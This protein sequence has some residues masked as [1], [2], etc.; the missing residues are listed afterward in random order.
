MGFVKLVIDAFI[1]SLC[2][3]RS[4]F[5]GKTLLSIAENKQA[6]NHLFDTFKK[7]ACYNYGYLFEQLLAGLDYF[8]TYSKH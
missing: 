8:L 6:I 1:T 2:Q 3:P 7:A 4:I 5:H